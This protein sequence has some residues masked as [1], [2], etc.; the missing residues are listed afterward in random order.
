MPKVSVVIPVYNVEKYIEQCAVS[1]FEQTLDDIEYI[2]VDDCT[3]DNSIDVLKKVI[4]RYKERLE[5]EKKHV[6]I[7]R[8]PQ[9]SGQAA[10]R[11][12]GI[13][14]SSG[15]YVIHCDSDDWAETTMYE[16]LYNKAKQEDA[17]IVVC[18]CAVVNSEGGYIGS[19]PK[20]IKNFDKDSIMRIVLT[21]YRLNQLWCSLVKRTL[22]GNIM[23][24]KGSQSEDKTYMIQF[25]YFAN[26]LIYVK[27][28]LYYYRNSPSS[29]TNAISTE[30]IIRRYN[31]TLENSRLILEFCKRQ[32]IIDKYDKYIKAYKFNVKVLLMYCINDA[33]CQK[34]WKLSYPEANKGVLFNRYIS[35]RNKYHYYR[36]LL[37]LLFS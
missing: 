12:H 6:I 28:S 27:E 35:L 8:M 33:E 36:C 22:F 14:K 11:E 21:E 30:S 10:V 20:A 31:Q 25:C 29:I 16:I 4:D 5:L 19:N 34:L 3:P 7:E 13:K 18:D 17:D 2:F 1:L 23:Y 37:H 26:K 24:P 15:D 32:G 9:N